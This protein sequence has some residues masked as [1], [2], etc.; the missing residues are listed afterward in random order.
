MKIFIYYIVYQYPTRL[1]VAHLNKINYLKS[2]TRNV[3]SGDHSDPEKTGLKLCVS[4]VDVGATI[5]EKHFTI[6]NKNETKWS[7]FS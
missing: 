3:G 7:S 2:L 1:E 4:A 5:I 6:L